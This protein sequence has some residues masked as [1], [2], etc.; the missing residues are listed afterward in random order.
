MIDPLGISEPNRWV[1]FLSL[2]VQ[3]MYHQYLH[4]GMW[5]YKE[6]PIQIGNANSLIV[7]IGP[8]KRAIPMRWFFLGKAFFCSNSHKSGNN[9]YNNLYSMRTCALYMHAV[10]MVAQD[11]CTFNM[12][13][14]QSILYI[15]IYI[16]D[17]LYPRQM[18]L[19]STLGTRWSSIGIKG[20]ILSRL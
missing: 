1:R 14:F 10:D 4:L 5:T 3:S 8:I 19:H 13:H 18:E 7:T 17:I 11:S 2:W 16:M 6:S 15:Y 20:N 9:P 12:V